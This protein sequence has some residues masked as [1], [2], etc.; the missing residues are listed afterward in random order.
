MLNDFVVWVSAEVVS[1]DV[2]S[3]GDSVVVPL[4]AEVNVVSSEGASVVVPSVVVSLV[5][6]SFG[7]STWHPV[8]SQD[9]IVRVSVV[10]GQ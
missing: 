9:V 3:F 1:F 4:V 6:V 5:V 7:V 10:I 8:S 2:V